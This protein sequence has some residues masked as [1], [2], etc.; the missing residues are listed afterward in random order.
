MKIKINGE[1]KVIPTDC[2]LD[3]FIQ[4]ANVQRHSFVVELNGQ[5]IDKDT[6]ASS[7]LK[8]DDTIEII[9]FVGG[10]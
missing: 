1:E 6:Y 9:R 10:G 7:F 5:I 4:Q 8:E 2:T 3:T